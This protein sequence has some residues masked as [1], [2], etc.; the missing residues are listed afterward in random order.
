MVEPRV[1]MAQ[2]GDFELVHKLYLLHSDS[3]SRK[4]K[5]FDQ[6]TILYAALPDAGVK[7][8]IQ[9][10]AIMPGSLFMHLSFSAVGFR[11]RV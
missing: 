2:E 1:G 8:Q 10:E 5:I 9:H 6:R 3:N 11:C 4:F 7:T